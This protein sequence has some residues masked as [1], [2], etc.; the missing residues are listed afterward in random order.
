M[1][2][3]AAVVAAG[4]LLLVPSMAQAKEGRLSSPGGRS[5]Y[6]PHETFGEVCDQTTRNFVVEAVI[7]YAPEGNI[8]MSLGW[9]L[10]QVEGLELYF[11][12]GLQVNPSAHLT[13][14]VRYYASFDGFRPYLGLGYLHQY[15]TAL[16]TRNH[17]VFA[18]IGHKWRIHTTYHLTIGVGVRYIFAITVDG[19]SPLESGAVDDELL[20]SELDD[21]ARFAP[22][23]AIRFSRAF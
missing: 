1:R 23:V 9:L 18:E 17:D 11:G 10:P 21:V 7:G 3:A 8:G 15:L 20:A 5:I 2:V 14:T 22:T 13:A 16:G 6:G 4:A 19:D 12:V